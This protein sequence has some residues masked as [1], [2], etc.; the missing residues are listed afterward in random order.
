MKNT[1]GK[2]N[3]LEK[4]LR[5][6]GAST[7]DWENIFNTITDMVTIHD[8]DFNIIYANA[9]AEK[10]LKLPSSAIEQV[11]CF[12]YYHGASCPPQGCPSCEC[13]TT[14]MPVDFEMFEPH[15]KRHIEIRALPRFNNKN[16]IAGI[17]HIVRDISKRKKSEKKLIDSR[18][19]LHNL[20]SH[21]ISIREREREIISREI[22]DQLGQLLTVMHM[23]LK[24]ICKKLPENNKFLH[25]RIR[26]MSKMLDMTIQTV[27]K[28][29]SDLRPK[30]LDELGLQ[31]AIKWQARKFQNM[32]GINCKLVSHIENINMDR[33]RDINI[34]RIFQ[35]T[36]TNVCRHANAT[37][38]EVSLEEDTGQLIMKVRDN[39][40]GI[41]NRQIMDSKSLGLI[42]M[43]ER[44]HFLQG[45]IE[46]Q[47]VPDKGT[48]VLVSIPLKKRESKKTGRISRDMNNSC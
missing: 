47:G 1:S 20:N 13:L 4:T 45:G 37:R 41:K 24:L 39:G 21:M 40:R 12:K 7:H 33:N 46:I 28:I 16:Q 14:G 22:H 36:L 23:D 34:F 3:A 19:Q 25:Q 5:P 11:K 26:S 18:R 10:N 6:I 44:V 27:Q 43:R 8:K 42:G 38:I 17:I 29:S 31:S 35:E 48:T 30:I 2:I 15:L 32:T 9:A